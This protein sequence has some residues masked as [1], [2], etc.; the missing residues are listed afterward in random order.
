M[1]APK[2]LYDYAMQLVGVPYI[3]AGDDPLIGLDC[4]GLVQ[5]IL[6]AAGMDPI[7]DQT[8]QALYDHYS[9][10]GIMNERGLGAIAFYGK[11]LKEINHVVFMMSENICIGANGGGS[12]TINKEAAAQ[13]N[14]FVKLRPLEYRKDLVAVIMPKYV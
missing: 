1:S 5:E 8:A 10:I 7:G 12:K 11:S 13:A 2:L 14:A 3:W 9:K 6:A 4:S